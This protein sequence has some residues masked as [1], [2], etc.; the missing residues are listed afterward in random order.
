MS[1]AKLRGRLLFAARTVWISVALLAIG[2]FVAG[3]PVSY[4]HYVKV[5]TGSGCGDWPLD[6]EDLSALEGL[7][8]S[9][10]FYATY[11]VALDVVHT[12][13]FWALA[14]FIFWRRSDD[15]VTLLISL[16]L[17]SFGTIGVDNNAL[18]LLQSDHRT[19][20]LLSRL[21]DSIALI[22]F[23]ASF[24]LFPDGRFVPR[25]TRVLVVVF[26]VYQLSYS[27]LFPLFPMFEMR[28]LSN[29]YSLLLLCLLSTLIFAQIYRYSR[30]SGPVERQQTK[31]VVFGLTAAIAILVGANLIGMAFVEFRQPGLLGTLYTL[32]SRTLV[33]LSFLFIPL[34]IGVAILRYRLW[35]IDLIINRT[36]VYVALT[37]SIIVFYGLVVSG[38]GALFRTDDDFVISLIATGLVA[39]MFAPLRYRLQRNVNRL[40]YGERDD[41]YD[42]LSRL[43]RRLETTLA[44]EAALETVAEVVAQALKL[45]YAAIELRQGDSYKKVAEY[46]DLNGENTV[47]PLVHQGETV[48]RLVVA[49]RSAGEE[50]SRQDRSLLEDLAWQ[51]G[52]AAHAALL[53]TDLRRSRERLVTA[54]EEERRRLRRDLHDGLGPT[55]GGLTLG[56]DAARSTLAGDPGTTD[57]LLAELKAQTREAVSDVRRLVHDLRPP[58]LDDLGLVSAIRQQAAKHG[59]LQG[60][61]VAGMQGASPMN[62]LAFTVDAPIDLPTLPAAVE[63][64]CYRI[65]QE[66]ITN[67]SRHARASTCSI[68]ISVEENR[69]ELVLEV[70]DDGVGMPES[71]RAG[72][73]MSSMRE[74]A[75][76]LGGTLRIESPAKEGGTRVL[77]WLPL[78]EEEER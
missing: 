55:L 48:G 37:V 33:N 32:G 45:P 26:I 23:F 4:D 21:I 34:S 20:W 47:L 49:P 18:Y 75:E 15:R 58:A 63:V 30:V 42:V 19:W 43:G 1:P 25:W 54:R 70:A 59:H 52:A 77:A 39:V 67:V 36:L 74:R 5:C 66:A 78:P 14:A 72:V 27:F 6:P 2:L 9:A 68:R 28:A 50:F 7:G 61:T 69:S 44:P 41:P 12:L 13:G 16:M 17:V 62:G 53:T 60:D 46:G 35:D 24:Y 31:W 3:V 10:G 57:E 76:E 38:L 8:L 51:A 56:L 29:L 71:R 64:A 40:M 73:G 65:G 22:T 11:N